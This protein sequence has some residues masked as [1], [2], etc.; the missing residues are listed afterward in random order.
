MTT[1]IAAVDPAGGAAI[2]EVI[3]ATAGALVATSLLFALGF[4]H[5][6]GRTQLLERWSAFAGRVGHLPPW[7]ALP[8]ALGTASLITALLGMYWDISLHIDNGRDAGPLANPAHYLILF[9]LF[10]IF[11]AGFLSM[12]IPR[13]RP[14]PTAIRL[15]D[16]WDV[17]LGGLL[18]A[19]AGGF[20]LIGFPLDDMWHR[21]FGQDV[22]LWGPT[23]LMLI[24]GASVSLIGQGV[25]LAEGTRTQGILRGEDRSGGV[26]LYLTIRRAALGGG[27]LIGLSTFQAEFDFGVPQF[28]FLFQPMLIALAASI[29][30]VSA[31]LWGGRG[32]ALGAVLFFIA[33]RGFVSLMVAGTWGE[34]TPHFPLYLVEALLVEGTA[35]LLLTRRPLA[36]GAVAGLLI[37]TVGTAAEWGWSHVWM[38][39]PWPAA[40][41]P[42]VAV[43]SVLAGLAGGLV[44][45]FIGSALLV[46]P[47]PFPRGARVVFPLAGL[48]VG[49]LVA[50]GLATSPQHGVSAQV[51]LL[52]VPGSGP[53]EVTAVVRLDPPQAADDAKWLTT[54]AWQGGGLVVDRLTRVREGVYRTNQPIPVSGDWK[55]E[56]RL[57][58]GRSLV[59]VPIY[60]PDD[61]AIPA[62]GVAARASFERPFIRDKQIL[63]REAKQGTGSLP[64]VGY[65]IVLAITLSIIALNAWALVRLA[66]VIGPQARP[67]ARRTAPVREPLPA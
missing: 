5:R 55:A 47:Q 12:C 46:K 28:D 58:S 54:T 23:H 24:G 22:T 35:A 14:C 7:V 52:D 50:F 18:M 59:G 29:G 39:L 9:G 17:P 16:G 11:A 61:P 49:G 63:Q 64:L 45:T 15:Y 1:L 27:F 40:L 57:H 20:A 51:Q 38:P 66:T 13:E 25:L 32:G 21:L 3:G 56:F 4:G 33:V 41:L 48:V 37:G 30:L 67:P 2:G 60:M 53:R 6:A 62:K 44:G 8:S 36:F 19:A 31:R 43:V 42:E 26:P 65:A 34:S 10:G